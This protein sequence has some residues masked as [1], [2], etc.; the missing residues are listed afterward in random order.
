MAEWPNG[1]LNQIAKP[2]HGV[3]FPDHLAELS[4]FPSDL[5]PSSQVVDRF[6]QLFTGHVLEENS[7]AQTE[8]LE[9]FTCGTG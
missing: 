4:H 6:A 9:T 8:S 1:L 7:L 2:L 5:F 3:V